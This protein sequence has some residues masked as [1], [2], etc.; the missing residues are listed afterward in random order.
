MKW[1]DVES[2]KHLVHRATCIADLGK[3]Y[4]EGLAGHSF[5]VGTETGEF[6]FYVLSIEGDILHQLTTQRGAV[7][8]LP[9]PDRLM[10]FQEKLNIDVI[11]I[12]A[13]NWN[14]EECMNPSKHSAE[15]RVRKGVS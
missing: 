2:N 6:A 10:R 4:Q 1:S 11:N 13:G 7:R 5:A 12:D 3:L 9:T 15:Y 8:R 14:E